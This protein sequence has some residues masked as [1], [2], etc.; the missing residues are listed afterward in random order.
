MKQAALA[1]LSNTAHGLQGIRAMGAGFLRTTGRR[2]GRPRGTVDYVKRYARERWYAVGLLVLIA[3]LASLNLKF[4]KPSLEEDLR[5]WLARGI[6]F[7]LRHGVFG[8]YFFTFR[9]STVVV[10]CM[11]PVAPDNRLAKETRKG[12]FTFSGGRL[13]VHLDDSP[14]YGKEDI[15]FILDPVPTR[16]QSG[17]PSLN[18]MPTFK[19][20]FLLSSAPPM[21]M[22]GLGPIDAEVLKRFGLLGDAE[23][24][25]LSSH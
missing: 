5:Q 24:I 21:D 3:I 8:C 11:D 25:V 15:T 10:H 12:T 1:R 6:T 9:G 17:M 20:R 7:G 4:S 22:I 14:Q 19:G 2:Q 23:S 13:R 16:L 18:Y